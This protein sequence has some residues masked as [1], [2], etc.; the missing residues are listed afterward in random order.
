MAGQP[1]VTARY[2][3]APIPPRHEL[4]VVVVGE[5]SH[6]IGKVDPRHPIKFFA[7]ARG[8]GRDV[9]YIPK[10]IGACYDRCRTGE[11]IRKCAR[12]L[13]D[14]PRRAGSNIEGPHTRYVPFARQY[15]GCGDI[16]YMHEVAALSAIF[17]YFGRF[18]TPQGRGE[19][20]S[21]A[22]IWRVAGHAWPVNIVITHCCNG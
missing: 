14:G 17:K 18:A 8:V 13:P 10:A 3:W 21:D 19:D 2:S 5:F 4:Q 7:N 1:G 12:H 11:C 6:A 20:R 15:G 22:S 9:S 16:P